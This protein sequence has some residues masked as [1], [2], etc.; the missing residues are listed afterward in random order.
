MSSERKGSFRVTDEE[1][2]RFRNL[3]HDWRSTRDGFSR[4]IGKALTLSPDEE[5]F[6]TALCD[7]FGVSRGTVRRWASGKSIPHPMTH[8]RIV[9]FV[10]SLVLQ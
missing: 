10:S 9:E 3:F 6:V 5:G 4:I 1:Y 2:R 8:P 7:E